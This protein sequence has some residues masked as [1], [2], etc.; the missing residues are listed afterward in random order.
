[1]A[2]LDQTADDDVHFDQIFYS[3]NQSLSVQIHGLDLRILEEY[4]KNNGAICMRKARRRKK[5]APPPQ[6]AVNKKECRLEQQWGMEPSRRGQEPSH[7]E[8][9]ASNKARGDQETG[10]RGRGPEY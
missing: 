2:C 5:V 10:R 9:K 8:R 4:S 3:D 7:W 6:A 1:M